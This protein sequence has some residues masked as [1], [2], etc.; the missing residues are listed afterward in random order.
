MKGIEERLEKKLE[1]MGFKFS[2]ECDDGVCEVW[3]CNGSQSY[4]ITKGVVYKCGT[5]IYKS[6]DNYI[7]ALRSIIDDQQ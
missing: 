5:G 3:I 2:D 7:S 4:Q 6:V 1:N